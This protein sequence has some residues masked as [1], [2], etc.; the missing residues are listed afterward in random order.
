[1]F[2]DYC[3]GFD[4]VPT[5]V[6]QWQGMGGGSA[7]GERVHPDIPGPHS[8]SKGQGNRNARRTLDDASIQISERGHVDAVPDNCGVLM[9]AG[10]EA[11]RR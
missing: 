3:C 9:A 7:G 8:Y 6:S 1:M 11:G 10:T 4:A 5:G 2:I